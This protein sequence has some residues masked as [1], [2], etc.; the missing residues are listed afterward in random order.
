M[1]GKPRQP[2]QNVG[3]AF[4]NIQR[5]EIYEVRVHNRSANEAA[6]SLT[7]D[8]LD[9]FTF[10]DVKDEKTGKP[11][12]SHFIVQPKSTFTIL[13]W[14]KTNDKALSFLVTEYGKGAS[15]QL[16]STGP[17]GVL[18][19]AFSA[20]SLH[21]NDLPADDGARSLPQNE[22][23]KGPPRDTKLKEVTRTIGVV[24]DII[25]VRYTR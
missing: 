9:V 1:K 5:D 10:S 16:K 13:G 19:A 6:V 14:H 20:C 22:T 2:G 11:L 8:G 12:Y 4:V 23:G 25:S 3:E 17:V 7:I 24:R 21:P 18:T 15:S